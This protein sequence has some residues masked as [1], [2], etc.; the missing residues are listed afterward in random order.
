[1]RESRIMTALDSG[2]VLPRMHVPL[3]G[4]VAVAAALVAVGGFAAHG[5]ND[6]GLRFGSQ[7]TWRFASLVYFAAVIAGPLARLL[8]WPWLKRLLVERRQLMWGFCASFGV[9]LAS[10]LAPNTLTPPSLDHEGLTIGMALFVFFGGGLT[11]VI[12]YAAAPQPNLGEQARR[13]ILAVGMAYF[14]LAYTLTGLS[15]LSGPHRPDGFYG[16]SLMLMVAALLLRFAD[17][18]MA[19]VKAGD[20]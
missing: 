7:L 6:N 16:F 5:F 14:W 9:F 12:A 4:M 17:R 19:K 8:P 18:L 3:W 20:A 1:M 11:I 2:A 15:H 13:A 10:L